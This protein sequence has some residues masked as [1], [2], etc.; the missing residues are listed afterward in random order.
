MYKYDKSNTKI[1]LNSNNKVKEE[2]QS[3]KLLFS[4]GKKMK[5]YN[6]KE[7]DDVPMIKTRQRFKSVRH[8]QNIPDLLSP[9]ELGNLITKSPGF[10]RLRKSI[11]KIINFTNMLSVFN[12][13]NKKSDPKN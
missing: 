8:N 10:I 13:N 11:P 7:Q 9:K 5:Y 4:S 12:N 2:S 1:I 3:N 6:E